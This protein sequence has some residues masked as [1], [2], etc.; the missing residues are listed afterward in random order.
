M[1]LSQTISVKS[2]TQWRNELGSL[3]FGVLR[4]YHCPAHEDTM[5]S[6]F[7]RDEQSQGRC[8]KSLSGDVRQQTTLMHCDVKDK[9]KICAS[10]HHEGDLL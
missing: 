2:S 3:T 8:E 9:A 6:Q 4:G 10:I 5:A 1:F 7:I